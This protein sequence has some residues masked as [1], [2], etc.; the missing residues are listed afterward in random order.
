MGDFRGLSLAII[1]AIFAI[2]AAATPIN[3]L[4]NPDFQQGWNNWETFAITGSVWADLHPTNSPGG[5]SDAAHVISNGRGGLVQ[6]FLPMNTGPDDL[7][8]SVWVYVNSG[9]VGMGVGNGGDTG[10]DVTSHTMH[11]W[12]QLFAPN[13]VSPAN[14]FI[15]YG[16]NG[17]D[18]YLAQPHVGAPVPEPDSLYL[19][20]TGLIL[21]IVPLSWLTN[22]RRVVELHPSKPPA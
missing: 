17:A 21:A 12:E 8:S 11:H 4:S 22:Q 6:V 9:Q 19:F 2:P 15:V 18:F 13:G 16:A 1:L 20:V 5:W 3:M 14:E 10:F 7:F